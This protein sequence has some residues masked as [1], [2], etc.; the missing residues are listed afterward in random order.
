MNFYGFFLRNFRVHF[1][2][3]IKQMVFL[4]DFYNKFVVLYTFCYV[5]FT[6]CLRD[7]LR[8]VFYVRFHAQSRPRRETRTDLKN[9]QV[10]GKIRTDLKKMFYGHF[11]EQIKKMISMILLIRSFWRPGLSMILLICSA[12]ACGVWI[13]LLICSAWVWW[14]FC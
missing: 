3:Q 4:L 10:R 6:Y 8:W 12:L 9:D 7:F 11:Y 13:I 1:G 14:W 2:E 5:L